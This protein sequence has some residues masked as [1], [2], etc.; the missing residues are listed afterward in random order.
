MLKSGNRPLSYSQKLYASIIQVILKNQ[1]TALCPILRLD[2]MLFPVDY[3]HSSLRVTIKSVS[4][5]AN[6]CSLM[7]TRLKNAHRK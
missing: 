1:M 2:V 7:V 5:S 4:F 3:L 6:T